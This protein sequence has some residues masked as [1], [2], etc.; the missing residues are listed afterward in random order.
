[1]HYR[2]E[3]WDF[4]LAGGGLYNKLDYSFTVDHEKGDFQYP[5]S[6]PGGGTLALR[7][8]L[9]ILKRFMESFD[10]LHMKPDASIVKGGLPEGVTVHALSQPGKAYA[11]YLK[12]GTQV[13][14]ELALPAGRYQAEWLDTKTGQMV[15]KEE[16]DSSGDV[17][18]PSPP[19][20]E[21]IALRIKA[22]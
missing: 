13:N 19:Y 3:A 14:L 10:F 11:L 2:T 18:L 7:K 17:T 5:N 21:D 1:V 15:K 4:L 22:R 8:Q 6:Q 16:L 20:S 9:S 12:G